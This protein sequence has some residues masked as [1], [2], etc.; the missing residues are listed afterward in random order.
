MGLESRPRASLTAGNRH[1]ESEAR[2]DSGCATFATVAKTTMGKDAV[3]EDSEEREAAV[4]KWCAL[5][6]AMGEHCK[7]GR[8]IA[9]LQGVSKGTRYVYDAFQNKA[10]DTL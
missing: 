9:C 2:A 1:D 10:A 4:A 7:L 5:V 6:K 8:E 3:T